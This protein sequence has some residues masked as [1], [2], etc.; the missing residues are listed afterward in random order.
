MHYWWD[1]KRYKHH[2]KQYGLLR[3]LNTKLPCDPAI[4][5]LGTDPKEL[6]AGSKETSVHPASTA[7]LFTRAKRWKEPL[8]PTTHNWVNKMWCT[9]AVKYQAALEREEILSHAATW[10]NLEDTM[11]RE[12]D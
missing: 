1:V 10:V 6:K 11:L 8:C 12:R 9:H 5:L 2:G 7:A 4:P 3:K